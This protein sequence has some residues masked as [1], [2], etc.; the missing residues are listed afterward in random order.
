MQ[1]VDE[2]GLITIIP[3]LHKMLKIH[4]ETIT[5]ANKFLAFV[6]VAFPLI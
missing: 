3:T 5:K 1:H 2:T 4:Q 6:K